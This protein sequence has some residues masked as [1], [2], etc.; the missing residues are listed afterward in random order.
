MHTHADIHT[1]TPTKFPD[2][3][4]ATAWA[5]RAKEMEP[6]CDRIYCC[7]PRGHISDVGSVNPKLESNSLASVWLELCSL[8]I[9]FPSC[10]RCHLLF[11][12]CVTVVP[13]MRD[14]V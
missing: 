14:F 13:K 10:Q 1:H 6:S 11:L 8:A 12:R 2:L 5:M 9:P 7:H 4:G 3:G